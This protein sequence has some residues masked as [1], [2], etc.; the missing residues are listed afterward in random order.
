MAARTGVKEMKNFRSWG[1]RPWEAARARVFLI[2]SPTKEGVG[3]PMNIHSACLEP[4]FAPA[5]KYDLFLALEMV[6]T[7][8]ESGGLTGTC[9]LETIVVFFGDWDQ[10]GERLC[11]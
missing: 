5:L 4:N 3:P 1:F 8:R 11:I 6:S 10:L 2:F 7:E 9:Q